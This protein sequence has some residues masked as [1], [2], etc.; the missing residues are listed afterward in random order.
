MAQIIPEMEIIEKI[1]K[2]SDINACIRHL[3]KEYYAMLQ[4]MVLTNNGDKE[5][6][7][8]VIQET[9]IT[10]VQIIQNNKFRDES[11]IKTFIYSVAKNIW[12]VQLKKRK[13]NLQRQNI[14]LEGKSD[15]EAD[16][17]EQMKKNEA[18]GLVS[19]VIDSLGNVCS[20]I[21][22]RFYYEDLSLKEILPFTNFENEQVLRNKK[23][24]CMKSLL[25][26]LDQNPNLKDALNQALKLF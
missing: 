12:L 25:E 7:E 15:F 13:A 6:S 23:S 24:K 21:L 3:Y 17:S 20:N 9:M 5:D 18:L 10:F 19:G 4:N 22:K 11:N 26:Q 14:W 2:N 1:R 16:I 8:D